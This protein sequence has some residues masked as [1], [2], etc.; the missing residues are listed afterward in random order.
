MASVPAR[1][2]EQLPVIQAVLKA[3][4]AAGQFGF[5]L[6]F[7]ND[8]GMGGGIQRIMAEEAGQV[9]K[10]RVRGGQ[11]GSPVRQRHEESA[12]TRGMHPAAA[13]F[14]PLPGLVHEPDIRPEK[15]ERPGGILQHGTDRIRQRLPDLPA[16]FRVNNHVRHG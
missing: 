5:P 10:Q 1:G 2:T 6:R 14:P 8:I 16:E 3:H 11:G 7:V 12:G 4:M 15:R 9:G 13:A